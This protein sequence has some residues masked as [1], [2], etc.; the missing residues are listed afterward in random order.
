MIPI[1]LPGNRNPH[2]TLK[3]SL[4]EIQEAR[5]NKMFGQSGISTGKYSQTQ[6]SSPKDQ[7]SMTF[8]SASFP[9]AQ[10]LNNAL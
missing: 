2:R 8:E 9:D 4:Q 6:P 7:L 10:K 5:S 3:E 1:G